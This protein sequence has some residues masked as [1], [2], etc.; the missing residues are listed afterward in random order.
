M[1]TAIDRQTHASADPEQHPP[2]HDP[3]KQ[4]ATATA[5]ATVTFV[6]LPRTQ[7]V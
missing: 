1:H 7:G 5:T 2:S 3:T 4:H 6:P